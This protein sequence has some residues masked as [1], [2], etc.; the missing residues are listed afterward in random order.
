MNDTQS[1]SVIK[2]ILFNFEKM[3]THA[4]IKHKNSDQKR[5]V[6]EIQLKNLVSYFP[7]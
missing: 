7:S 1:H 6:A 4:S 3:V 5:E 2:Y